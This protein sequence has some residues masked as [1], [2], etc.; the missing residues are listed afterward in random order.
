M[1]IAKATVCISFKAAAL[2]TLLISPVM[3]PAAIAAREP[4]ARTFKVG[5]RTLEGRAKTVCVIEGKW[6][7]GEPFRYE[8]WDTCNELQVSSA[9]L[10]DY[11]DWR[12]RGG[13]GSLTVADIPQ[14]A[15]TIE[16]SNDF[17]S[18]LVFRDRDGEMKEVLI[19][20]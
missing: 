17:S 11:K 4:A 16:I 5:G 7:D 13:E 18:V 3:T 14:G 8:G 6:A 10:A 12:P 9:S 1:T 2:A 19:R 15:E 20:D